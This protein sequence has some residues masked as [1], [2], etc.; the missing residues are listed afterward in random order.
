M[1]RFDPEV[2]TYRVRTP[3]AQI[4]YYVQGNGPPLLI[5]PSL[6][7]G[8]ADYDELA[9]L[10]AGRGLQVI[11]P[12]PRGI[13]GSTGPMAGLSMRDLAADVAEVIRD[14]VGGPAAVAGHAFGNFVARMLANAFPDTVRAVALV[15]ASAGR[16]P[17]G[18]SPYDPEVH[19]SIY[20]S[21]DLSLPVDER[22]AHLKR[23]FF[24]FG[25]DP[26]SWLDGWY[27][28]TKAMQKE[29]QATTSIDEYFDCGTVP[30]FDLQAADDMVA[31]RRHAHVLREALGARV[32]VQVIER[33]GHAL[34][35]EQPQA[36]CDALTAWMRS[37]E[38]MP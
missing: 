22:I 1:N 15:A 26:S 5:L 27:P 20:A 19:A 29:A 2:R 38:P 18:G 3:D 16:L 36:V 6:G 33:A 30:V 17:G 4:E 10:L 14:R 13:G 7:R 9:K 25:N 34:I 23:A 35:P 31:P 32:T 8:A 28:S 37:L 12:Q 11:R 21:G 24:A